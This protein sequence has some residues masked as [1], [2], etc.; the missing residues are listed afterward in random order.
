MMS[1]DMTPDNIAYNTL[2]TCLDRCQQ[3]AAAL[4]WLELALTHDQ[5]DEAS[6]NGAL[7]ALA[8][9]GQWEL[10][11]VI[12]GSAVPA[13]PAWPNLDSYSAALL[14]CYRAPSREAWFLCFKLMDDMQRQQL[15]PSTS[16]YACATRSC[17]RGGEWQKA[18]DLSGFNSDLREGE[19]RN[20]MTWAL[21]VSDAGIGHIPFMITLPI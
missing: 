9:S 10:L 20:A 17:G 4:A 16:E 8:N 6:L 3:W 11:L 7:D 12:Q 1:K 14:A 15:T 21:E 18:Y 19:L 5:A 2:I 13:V